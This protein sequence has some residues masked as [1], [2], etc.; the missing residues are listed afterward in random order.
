M[1][2]NKKITEEEFN[3]AVKGFLIIV[4]FIVLFSVLSYK[5]GYISGRLDGQIQEIDNC[6]KNNRNEK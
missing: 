6:I 1:K 4:F 5:L 2:N 3:N